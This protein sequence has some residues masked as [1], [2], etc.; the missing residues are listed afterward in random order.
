MESIHAYQT[1]FTIYKNCSILDVWLGSEYAFE[2]LFTKLL[3]NIE[4]KIRKCKC[5]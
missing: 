2:Y 5:P 1:I 3:Y 4:T